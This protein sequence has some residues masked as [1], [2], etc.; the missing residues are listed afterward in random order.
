[1]RR[2]CGN[3]FF[4]QPDGFLWL[5]SG[6]SPRVDAN[7]EQ[8]ETLRWAIRAYSE[9]EAQKHKTRLVRRAGVPAKPGN[10]E[11]PSNLILPE[12]CI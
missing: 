10:I 6:T 3:E 8:A 5:A 11:G 7:R 9:N 1:M 4:E 2:A 12:N